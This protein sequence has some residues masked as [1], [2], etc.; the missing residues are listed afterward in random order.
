MALLTVTES[1]ADFSSGRPEVY[2]PGR[3]VDENDPVVK[4][5]ERHFEAADAAA[6]RV[7]VESATA[8]PGE[9]RS[10]SRAAKKTTSR[11]A[12]KKTAA[13]PAKTETPPATVEPDT[14]TAGG[15]KL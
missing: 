13:A 10:R 14:G 7:R 11:K 8:A 5:R 12:A 9:R 1:F 4:G 15:E 6:A 2:N 3:L